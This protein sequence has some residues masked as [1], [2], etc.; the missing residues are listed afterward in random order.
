M[1]VMFG[2]TVPRKFG[3]PIVFVGIFGLG[4]P[5]ALNRDILVNQ[6]SASEGTF[7]TIENNLFSLKEKRDGPCPVQLHL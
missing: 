3:L 2:S 5:S 6:V 4:I 1:F 7:I